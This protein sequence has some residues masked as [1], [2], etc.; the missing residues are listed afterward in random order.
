MHEGRR[1][2]VIRW[3]DPQI[4]LRAIQGMS[5]LEM[6]Q[7]MI[8][9]TLP[10]PPISFL[11]NFRPIELEPGRAV[12]EGEPGEE[13]YNPIG[14]VHGGYALTILD[15]V[16]GVAI[17][18]MLEAG[19]GFTTTDTQVRFV[20]AITKDTG[21]VRCEARVLHLGRSTGISEGKLVDK[22][23]KLLATGT[24]ACAIMRR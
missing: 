22:D 17:H 16:L 3:E 11:M 2:R 20:R 19:V 10:R 9:G 7:A 24:T 21:I 4:A 13:H 5:G 1:E 14:V 18:S 23:G 6:M 12:F 8:A 15:T